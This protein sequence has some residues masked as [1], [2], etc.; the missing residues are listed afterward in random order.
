MLINLSLIT[1][2]KSSNNKSNNNLMLK[3]FGS[4]NSSDSNLDQY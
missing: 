1:L 2:T 4:V 3:G